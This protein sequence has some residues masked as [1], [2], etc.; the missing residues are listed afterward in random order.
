MKWL[1]AVLTFVNLSVVC[2]L[3]LGMAGRGLNVVSAWLALVCGAAF[4]VAAYLGTSDTAIRE[5]A[6]NQPPVRKSQKASDPDSIPNAATWSAI[7]RYRHVWFWAV[8]VC[9]AMFAVRSFCWFFYIDGSDYKIQSPNNLGDLSLHL[10]LIKSFANGV[11]LWPDNPI[12][13]FSKLQYP[14]GIDLFNALLLLVHVDLITGLVWVGLVASLAT[15]YAF[16]RWGRTFAVAGFL[17]NGGIAGFQFFQT[18]K[19]LDYQG[20]N[21]I[22]WKSIP[23][24]MFVTQRGWLYAIPAGLILLW[25][26][27]EKFFR[28]PPVAAADDPCHSGAVDA[29]CYGKG[30]LPFWVEFSLYASMPLFHIHTFLALTIV[31]VIA[32][33]FERPTEIAFIVDRARK[34]GGSGIVRLIWHPTMWP[35]IFRDAPLRRHAAVLLASALI[36]ASFFVWLVTDHFRAASIFKWHPGWAQDSADFAAPFFRIGG[37]ASFGSSTA[38]GALLQKMWNGVIAPFF[39]FWLPNFGLWVPLALALVGLCGWRIWKAGWRWGNRPPAD[40]AFV[41]PAVVIFAVGYFVKT[42]PW[43]WDNLKLMVWGYFMILP[44][45]WS[46]IIGRW[47]FPERAAMCI[48]LF[49]SGFVTLLGGLSA[50]HPGF[51]LIERARLDYAG[52]ALRPLPVE[53]RFA[54]YPTYNHPVLLQGRKAVLGYPGHLWTEG[55]NSTDASNRLT[56]LMNGAANWREAAKALGVRYVFWGQD[57]K[58]NYQSSSRPWEAKSFLVASGDWG[59]IYDLNSPAP[60]H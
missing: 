15:F 26:W 36:P 59:A 27:R 14:A 18:F 12:Y 29:R 11:A 30:P 22:A 6:A 37:A 17:F 53:A 56:E 10:T 13:V 34:E 7:M 32:L 1:S 52:A 35:E 43:D 57:E 23:L 38:F 44:F 48:A 33:F 55:F 58:T 16:F 50:G 51:G 28:E 39:Q 40:I 31:L 60:Q 21:K 4:A 54:S 49:G 2:G 5:K 46:D 9:F 19:F 45:L 24:A 47:A 25:H 41:L 3:F 42:A 8:A 20:G